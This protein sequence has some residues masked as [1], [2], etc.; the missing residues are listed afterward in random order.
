MLGRTHATSASAVVHVGL[1]YGL[2][3]LS[4]DKT[5]IV[6]DIT[7]FDTTLIQPMNILSYFGVMLGTALFLIWLLRIGMAQ[8]RW[9]ALATIPLV[10]VFLWFASDGF[11]PMMVL[12]LMLLFILGSLLPD[13]D[14][15]NS[16]LGRYVKLISRNIPHRTITH[17]L[18][19]VIVLGLLVYVLDSIYLLALTLGYVFH[20]VEDS[21]S[22]QGI[23]WLYPISRYDSFGSGATVK[24]RWKGRK[25][26]FAYR[27][28]GSFELVVLILS[29]VAH[30]VAFGFVLVV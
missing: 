22:K 11:Y 14:S 1:A 15:E 17:T 29:I 20:I 23:C 18:W 19:V 5:S 3:Q 27:T 9:G 24:R 6:R 16:T 13:I 12:S 4:Q 25:P 26:L 28:G 10:Y 8:V 21:F 2:V 7:V 30:L